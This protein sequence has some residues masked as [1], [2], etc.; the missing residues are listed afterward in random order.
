MLA[1]LAGA[2]AHLGLAVM[3]ITG[4]GGVL[5]GSLYLRHQNLIGVTIFHCLLGYQLRY[6]RAIA[7]LE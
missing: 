1:R 3:A 2:I 4:V 5:F 6:F 7:F